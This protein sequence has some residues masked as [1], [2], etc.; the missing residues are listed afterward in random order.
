M[1]LY[2]MLLFSPV[3]VGRVGEVGR[4]SMFCCLNFYWISQKRKVM[5]IHIEIYLFWNL[6]LKLF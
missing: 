6:I 5:F 2:R 4:G 3:I 1:N